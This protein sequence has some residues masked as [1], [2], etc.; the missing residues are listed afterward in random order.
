[1]RAESSLAQKIAA[2]VPAAALLAAT[3]AS[4]ATA[5]G[6]RRAEQAALD[7][8]A[9]FLSAATVSAT[10]NVRADYGERVYDF[11]LEYAYSDGE[12]AVTVRKPD[13]IAGITARVSSGGATIEWDGASVDTGT[14]P[15]GV[16]P[17]VLFAVICEELKTGYIV[18]AVAGKSGGTETLSVT[19]EVSGEVSQTTVFALATLTPLTSELY[20][21]GRLVLSAQYADFVLT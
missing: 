19:T 1:M 2:A 10:A 8:R 6:S 14:L 3:L 13:E 18:S 5:S 12:C 4:C 7:V 11:A 9:A 17:A 20:S 16:S 21:A 15:G